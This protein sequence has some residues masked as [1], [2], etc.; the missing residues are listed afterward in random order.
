MTSGKFVIG[1]FALGMV[2]LAACSSSEETTPSPWIE[3]S[4]DP[5][6]TAVVSINNGQ[7]RVVVHL[8]PNQGP[9]Q[10]GSATLTSDGNTTIVE[11]VL[12]PTVAEAQPMHIHVGQC[13]EVGSVLHAL[14]NIVKGESV[15]TIAQPLSEILEQGALVNVHA[16]YTD[17]SNYTACGPLPKSLQ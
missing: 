11:V 13:D 1:L 10:T 7:S 9:G 17:A 14:E 4:D 6:P 12:S 15:T 5:T 16:S 8:S 2:A 3:T